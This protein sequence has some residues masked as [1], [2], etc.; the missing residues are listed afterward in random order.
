MPATYSQSEEMIWNSLLIRTTLPMETSF[1]FSGG[2]FR[3]AW[4]APGLQ[5]GC[6]GQGYSLSVT[7]AG[8]QERRAGQSRLCLQSGQP[9]TCEALHIVTNVF[10]AYPKVTTTGGWG[11]GRP[12]LKIPLVSGGCQPPGAVTGTGVYRIWNGVDVMS[13]RLFYN[14]VISCQDFTSD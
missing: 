3:K 6:P 5:F 14:L 7:N 11:D 13:F 9:L 8:G 10:L 12:G 4:P 2:G 1:W